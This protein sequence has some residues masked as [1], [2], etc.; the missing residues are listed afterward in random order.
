MNIPKILV[1]FL[2]PSAR[3]A[4]GNDFTARSAPACYTDHHLHITWTDSIDWSSSKNFSTARLFIETIKQ[5]FC[6]DGFKGA[7]CIRVEVQR[8]SIC[9]MLSAETLWFQSAQRRVPNQHLCTLFTSF[10]CFFSG[11]CSKAALKQVLLGSDSFC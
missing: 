9:Q 4:C 7:N 6:K 1:H 5:L 2:L 11:A 10:Y 3:E 8:V